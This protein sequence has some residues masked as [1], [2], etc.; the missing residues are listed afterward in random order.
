LG[1]RRADL[2]CRSCIPAAAS[3]LREALV[4]ADHKGVAHQ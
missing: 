4:S 3:P 2:E 1:L